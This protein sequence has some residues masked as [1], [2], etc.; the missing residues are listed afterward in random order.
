MSQRIKVLNDYGLDIHLNFKNLTNRVVTVLPHSF[1]YITEDELLFLTNSSKI[2]Q[3]GLL[4]V[5]EKG[6]ALDDVKDA[7]VV[8]NVFTKEQIDELLQ[9]TVGDIKEWIGNTTNK[10]GL[11]KLLEAAKEHNK[12]K[13]YIEAIENKIEELS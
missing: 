13:G 12:A 1:S 11:E 10:L 8:E 4:T 6:Q 3:S 9:F 7:T 2:I 5:E